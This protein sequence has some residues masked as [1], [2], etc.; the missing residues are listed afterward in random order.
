[1]PKDVYPAR[2]L[3]AGTEQAG[4]REDSG[5]GQ[6]PEED[7]QSRV[8]ITARHH[9]ERRRPEDGELRQEQDGG[10]RIAHEHCRG[11]GRDEGIDPPQGDGREIADGNR[12]NDDQDQQKGDSESLLH[13][14][15]RQVGKDEV[16]D[17]GHG[18]IRH[19]PGRRSS[20]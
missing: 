4:W 12:E 6:H 14:T 9:E 19:F 3:K 10:E 5:E 17:L 20:W 7:H 8:E 16:L 18:R 13:R 2:R 1:V 11:V 15:R